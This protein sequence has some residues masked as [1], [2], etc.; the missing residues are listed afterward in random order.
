MNVAPR[1]VDVAAAQAVLFLGQHDDAA[2]FGRFVGQR[3]QLRR[4]GQVRAGRRRCRNQFHRLPIAHRDRA[5]LVQQQHV[6]VAGRFDRPARHGDHVGLD[7]AV[8]AGDAD[9]REQAA[10]RRR[11]QADQQRDEHRHRD[12]AALPGRLHA[13][14]RER[15]QRRA[16]EQKD[17]RHRRQQDVERDFVRRLLPLGPFD[18]PD[19]AVE[20][21]FARI[22][23]DAHDQPV[24][25][26]ARAAGDAAAV[27]AAFA[28]DRGAFAGDG[29]FV[30]RGH[31]FDD[32]AVA[33]NQVA[34]LDQH[35][36]VLSAAL[37]PT[38]G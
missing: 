37:P 34:R 33:G 11:N 20:K 19:H 31:A 21:R 12:R 23:R 5:G 4:I 17:D 36:V 9:G 8:H 10:D 14:L 38:A 28:D 18:Q 7:H 35:D 16:D 24:G 1:L 26:H 27:A 22:G 6:D 13:V 30:D 25:Q 29:A 32:F 15:Q 3:R 2:P